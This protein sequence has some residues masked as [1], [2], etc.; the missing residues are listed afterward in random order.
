MKVIVDAGLA[1]SLVAS[2]SFCVSAPAL[3]QRPAPLGTRVPSQP[4]EMETT[5]WRASVKVF[6]TESLDMPRGADFTTNRGQMLQRIVRS[7]EAGNRSLTFSGSSVRLDLVEIVELPGLSRWNDLGTSCLEIV[8]DLEAE[9]RANVTRYAFRT[10]VINLYVAGCGGGGSIAA[11]ARDQELIV[12]VPGFGEHDPVHE[13]GHYFGLLHTH[14]GGALALFLEQCAALRADNGPAFMQGLQ[15]GDDEIPET[16]P[17]HLCWTRDELAISRFEKS[18]EWLGPE[19]A[20]QVDDT[21]WNV[22][23]YHSSNQMT[24]AERLAL[25]TEETQRRFTEGQLDRMREAAGDWRSNVVAR[26]MRRVVEVDPNLSPANVETARQEL[27][28]EAAGSWVAVEGDVAWLKRLELSPVPES[29][30][31]PGQRGG[32]WAEVQSDWTEDWRSYQLLLVPDV[33]GDAFVGVPPTYGPALPTPYYTLTYTARLTHEGK[34]AVRIA[35]FVSGFDMVERKI[36]LERPRR[37]VPPAS[38]PSVERVPT[39]QRRRL[40]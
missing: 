15:A 31:L 40:P 21:F 22:M 7:I 1:V 36:V 11:M 17:D 37:Y 3:G 24:A 35:H 14:N 25:T 13:I 2:L 10:D 34:L 39:P 38:R 9:A 5:L 12:L 16:L 27:A 18:Y 32:L 23:S 20:R 26:E 4:I 28:Q 8:R 33:Y 29:W 30:P 19:L 6:L